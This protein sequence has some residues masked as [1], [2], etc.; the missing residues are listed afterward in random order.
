MAGPNTWHRPTQS[1]IEA[2]AG[3]ALHRRHLEDLG[4][5]GELPMDQV[6]VVLVNKGCSLVVRKGNRKQHHR[7]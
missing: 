2:T 6:H 3:P 4:L 7:V 1:A 5:S